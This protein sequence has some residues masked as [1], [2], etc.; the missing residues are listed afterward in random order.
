MPRDWR[1]AGTR[2]WCFKAAVKASSQP[3][4]HQGCH[5]NASAVVTEAHEHPRR[6]LM[7]ERQAVHSQIDLSRPAIVNGQLFCLREQPA[8]RMMQGS[9]EGFALPLAN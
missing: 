7:N 9:V 5:R 3:L 4:T 8:H 6:R 2:Q 1:K